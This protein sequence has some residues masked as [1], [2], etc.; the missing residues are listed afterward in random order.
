MPAQLTKA[1]LDVGLVTVNAEL[2][3]RFYRDLLG[4]TAGYRPPIARPGVWLY[5]GK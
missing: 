3:L 1:A 5:A 4:F 2:A